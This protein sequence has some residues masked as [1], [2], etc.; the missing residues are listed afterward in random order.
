MK[1]RLILG[2]A[3]VLAVGACNDQQDPNTG[4]DQGTE[5]ASA[6]GMIGINVLLKAP[7]TAQ[8]RTELAKYG[9][10]I[11]EIPQLNVIRVK[12]KA[13]ELAAIQALPFVKT[14]NPDAERQ[15]IPIDAVAAADFANGISTWD[16]DAINVTDFGAGRTIGFD[17]TGVW[18][19]ILDTGLLPTWRQYFPQERIAEEYAKTFIGGGSENGNVSEPPNKWESDVNSHGTHVTSTVI[20]Y[21][22]ATGPRTVNG[23]APL[24]TII[25]VKVLNQSGSGWSSAIARGIM[26]IVE[27]K[28]TVL[29]NDPVVINMSLSGGV[30][31]AV[32]Q[33]AIDEAVRAGVIIVAAASNTGPTGFMGYP[34]AYRPV[35]SVASVGYT[36][37]WETTAWWRDATSNTADPTNPAEYYVSPFSSLR[38]P[39]RDQD[40]DVAA[41]GS[42]VVGPY[43]VNQSNRISFFFLN[44]TSMSSPHVAGIVALML[45]KNPTLDAAAPD[46]AAT[47]ERILETTAIQ[48]PYDP[49]TAKARPAFGAPLQPVPSWTADRSGHGLA[50]ANAAVGATP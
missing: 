50:T 2:L 39:S 17:G 25:P 7:A 22:M 40:L 5:F 14:A 21:E 6:N 16:Q 47:A 18:V 9:S 49:A 31:D 37:Q 8:N 23:T 45:D 11:D 48:I 28:R 44:G 26:Y 34:G 42:L 32:E 36:R 20:G 24:A 10:L 35:I 43:Q 33:A 12:A 30:L 1:R 15:A 27:L 3:A 46:R 4:A 29:A 41:P 19:A 38:D 13:S